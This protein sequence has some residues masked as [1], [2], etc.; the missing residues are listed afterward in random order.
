MP[1][2]APLPGGSSNAACALIMAWYHLDLYHRVIAC[3]GTWTNQQWPSN[4]E[5]PHGAG[6]LS[7]QLIPNSPLKPIRIWMTVGDFDLLNPNVM[8][9]NMHDWITANENLARALAARSCKQFQ[10]S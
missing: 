2:P 6:E 9:D 1:T 3:S 8:R 4:L 7:E 10:G 5:T